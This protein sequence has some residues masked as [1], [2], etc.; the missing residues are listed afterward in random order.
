MGKKHKP[1]SGSLAFYPRKRARSEKPI[2]RSFKR[3]GGE[4]GAL[5]FFGYK[6]GMSHAAATDQH[7]KSPT[8]G[9]KVVC[10][11]T[12]IECPPI[13]VVG[14][15]AYKA[16]TSGLAAFAE[17]W[18]KELPK[19]AS[20]TIAALGKKKKKKE[21]KEGKTAI[22]E[23]AGVK[24]KPGEEEKA[25]EKETGTKGK[26]GIESIRENLAS[27]KE[28]RLIG[29]LQPW[30]TGIGKKKPEI[31]EIFLGGSPE[32]QFEFAQQSLGKELLAK[33]VF[34]ENDFLDVR[35][36]T[37]G[38]GFSGVVK[39]F[40]VKMQTRKGKKERIVG[41]IG[42]WH[43][44]TVMYTVARAGQLGY[45]SRTE[46]NKKLLKID[47]NAEIN[48]G[49]GFKNYGVIRNDYM[50]LEGSVPGPSKRCIAMRRG[51]R[52]APLEKHKIEGVE[53][54][55]SKAA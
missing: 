9:Q 16:T 24:G 45:Q 15:R 38:K 3:E 12:F 31:V 5:N 48:P 40:G 33:D 2:I 27:V 26:K 37:K 14:V 35:A 42:P 55:A 47:N 46:F 44:A 52:P 17:E 43:P 34:N 1:R 36:V 10:A 8:Y 13:R 41:S 7:Q 19:H 18:A 53:F 39:R 25:G 51:I 54:I 21:A 29:C 20:R 22:E 49:G 4:A 6:A 50:L 28:V 30:L 23:K 32:K 11:A